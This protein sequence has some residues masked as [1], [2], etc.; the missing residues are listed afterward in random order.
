MVAEPLDR[1]E[2]ARW[3]TWKRACDVVMHEVEREIG[4]VAGLSGADF[5]VLSRVVEVGEGSLRQQQLARLLGWERSR[6]SRQLSRMEERGLVVRR[7]DG[8]IGRA[9]CRE[10]V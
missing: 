1:V 5:A 7:A 8:Q 3:T 10:R 4:M 6:L 2:M 9:S